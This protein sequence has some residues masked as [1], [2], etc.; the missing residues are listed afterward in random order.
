MI[1]CI[2][3][4][5]DF[6][7]SLRHLVVLLCVGAQLIRLR[8]QQSQV[9]GFPT[10]GSGPV[11]TE[12][13][14]SFYFGIWVGQADPKSDVNG[15]GNSAVTPAPLLICI[16]KQLPKNKV[17]Q[18]SQ[19]IVQYTL[20]HIL[21]AKNI[22]SHSKQRKASY[23]TEWHFMEPMTSLGYSDFSGAHSLSQLKS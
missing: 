19:D 18:M 23:H 5:Q 22:F 11:P 21:S 8:V 13:V 20:S 15:Y 16:T 1:K 12:F 3:T 2:D 10:A 17:N 14:L 4:F 6:K 9:G 7:Y